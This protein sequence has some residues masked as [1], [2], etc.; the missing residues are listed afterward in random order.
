MPS[1][2]CS[3]T[4]LNPSSLTPPTPQ[5]PPPRVLGRAEVLHANAVELRKYRSAT[6]RDR[7]ASGSS[8][9]GVSQGA[10]AG[11]GVGGV[12]G[13]GVGM[14]G[15]GGGAIEAQIA[16]TSGGGGAGGGSSGGSSTKL[17][18]SMSTLSS[19]RKFAPA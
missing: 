2:V 13:M 1:S 12:G 7:S 18:R 16:G 19:V 8:F 11:A 6:P 5:Q 14:M 15:M 3:R 4:L 10:G 9:S 17:R